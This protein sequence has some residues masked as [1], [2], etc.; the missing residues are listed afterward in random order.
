[1]RFDLAAS[2]P[3]A[4]EHEPRRGTF[5]RTRR[6][7]VK[8]IMI[9]LGT[10][11]R[12]ERYHRFV[13]DSERGERPTVAARIDACRINAVVDDPDLARRKAEV[14]A[15]VVD[16]SPCHAEV[17]VRDPVER[18]IEEVTQ[19]T[20]RLSVTHVVHPHD[21]CRYA[22]Q[23]CRHTAKH[24]GVVATYENDV[25]SQAT[26]LANKLDQRGQRRAF[27]PPERDGGDVVGR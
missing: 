23:V 11:G 24:F 5:C 4:D 6:A 22:S 19:T 13:A 7:A 12:H 3:I 17:R 16:L 10:H 8:N 20:A 9:L 27:R 25:W 26:Q 14:T 1:V 21:C 18:T 2:R 15:D